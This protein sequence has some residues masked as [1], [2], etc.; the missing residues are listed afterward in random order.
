MSP[1]ILIIPGLKIYSML[2]QHSLL[3]RNPRLHYKCSRQANSLRPHRWIIS[4]I[5]RIIPTVHRRISGQFQ[6]LMVMTCL[7]C[8]LQPKPIIP[9]LLCMLICLCTG[10]QW[11][12]LRICACICMTTM[13]LGSRVIKSTPSIYLMLCCPHQAL[14]M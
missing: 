2:G 12:V 9:A 4:V 13:V 14:P 7:T 6:M 5:Y 11:L 1:S 10:L 8:V 3:S